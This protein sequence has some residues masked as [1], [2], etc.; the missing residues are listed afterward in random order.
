MIKKKLAAASV[1][2]G[3]GLVLFLILRLITGSLYALAAAGIWFFVPI[4]SGLLNLYV[5]RQIQAQIQVPVTATKGNAFACMVR[6]SGNA[7][8]PFGKIWCEIQCTNQLTA[9]CSR[10]VIELVPEA[11]NDAEGTFEI[12]PAFCGYLCTEVRQIVLADWFGFLPVRCRISAQGT[13]SVLPD[14]FEMQTEVTLSSIET[15][16]AQSWSPYRKGQDYSEVFALRE[17]VP[18]DSLKQ[19]HW[20]LSGKRGQ[21]IVRDPSLPLAESLLVFWDKNTG[22]S[23]PE[24][25]DAMAET[26]ASLCQ[27]VLRQGITFS[28]G[29]TDGDG[30]AVEN[31]DTEEQL[32]QSIPQM[33]KYGADSRAESGASL[34]SRMSGG[35][36]Y[37]KVLYIARSNPQGLEEFPAGDMTLLL[38]DEK[39]PQ[40]E[41]RVCCF[42]AEDYMQ[43]LQTIE[44]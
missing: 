30:C 13:T 39:E 28:L 32:I 9:E 6:I 5:R 14:M 25:M 31:I 2:W 21:L 29:W 38:C 4:V 33:V 22:T 7:F 1:R 18:G 8:V 41:Y 23:T 11:S 40:T 37:G 34:Y 15:D 10:N 42:T 35:N 27:A 36:G 19:I 44:L 3:A 24:E 17:Y 20:K 43:D 12:V 26:T 16:D